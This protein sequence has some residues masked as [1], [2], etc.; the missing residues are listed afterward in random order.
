MGHKNR[1]A[2]CKNLVPDSETS[3]MTDIMWRFKTYD[4]ANKDGSG[5][6]LTFLGWHRGYNVRSSTHYNTRFVNENFIN[7]HN[8]CGDPGGR[9]TCGWY[10]GQ[11]WVNN[12]ALQGDGRS[13]KCI[14][15]M[16]WCNGGTIS[17]RH[18]R[19]SG[20][21]DQW[22]DM[23]NSVDGD[24]NDYKKVVGSGNPRGNKCIA[25][26]CHAQDPINLYFK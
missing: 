7:G 1:D 18:Q 14:D 15:L 3:K 23:W 21:S 8:N 20:G 2:D 17:E 16:H 19:S 11:Q 5:R 4:N 26:V 9:R 6:A 22:I 10:K 24:G 13:Y 12:G 25:A